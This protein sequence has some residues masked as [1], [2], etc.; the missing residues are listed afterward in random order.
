MRTISRAI[1]LH[2]IRYSDSRIIVNAYTRSHGVKT[3]LLGTGKG[4]R[5]VQASSLVQP[6]TIVD[7][8]FDPDQKGGVK[9]PNSWERAETFSS[10]PFDTVKTSIALFMAELILRSVNEEEQNDSLFQFLNRSISKLDGQEGSSANFHLKFMLELSRFLGFYPSIHGKN[11]GRFFNLSE[12]EFVLSQPLA[13]RCLGEH[14]TAS[15][16][17]L[18]ESHIDH[19]GNIQIEPGVR[20]EL[21]EGLIHY[22]RIHLEGMAEMRSHLV[23]KEVLS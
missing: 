6:L 22:F 19:C 18:L 11:T 4:K 23:L 8:G 9:R 16:K 2:A 10:I 20:K 5:A 1:V 13:A 21:L 3:F 17:K 15:L 12:G 14:E 7:V